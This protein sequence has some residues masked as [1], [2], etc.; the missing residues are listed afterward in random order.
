MIKRLTRQDLYDILYGCTILG[1]GG[2]GEME[3]GMENFFTPDKAF[4]EGYNFLDSRP[5]DKPFALL[6]NFNVPHGHSTGSMQLR[7][8][9][10]ALYRTAY[11][12]QIE[13]IE[14]ASTYIAEADIVCPAD[15]AISQLGSISDS[16]IFQAKGCHY[17]LQALL[18]GNKEAAER[19][20]SKT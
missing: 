1:T 4:Q 5:K 17:S 12:D 19:P 18:G 7:E 11:R 10:P 9:D 16:R 15:G 6:L 8:T 13:E 2:G 14:L 3:E 20:L